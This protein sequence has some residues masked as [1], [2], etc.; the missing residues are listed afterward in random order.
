MIYIQTK[1]KKIPQSCNKCR[2]S[3]QPNAMSERYCYLT[4]TVCEKV[5]KSGTAWGYSRNKDCPL[6]EGQIN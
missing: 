4:D 5:K 3:R 6:I 1:L 2:F